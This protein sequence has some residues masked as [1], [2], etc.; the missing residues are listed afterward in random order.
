MVWNTT[1]IKRGIMINVGAT[2]KFQKNIMCCE[3]N[4]IRSPTACSCENGE[5]WA[6]T[7]YNLLLTSNDVI[8]DADSVSTNVSTNVTS[9]ES[10]KFHN[11]KIGYKRNCCILSRVLLV[12][13][14]LFIIIIICYPFAKLMSNKKYWRT[15]NSKWSI[16]NFKKLVLNTVV[17]LF[18][19]QLNSKILI[20]MI[21]Y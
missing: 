9:V 16:I 13:I 18:Q 10:I 12:I 8:N 3:K 11:K 7:T 14:S 20:L 6:R 17:L 5:Y 21:L 1:L 15:N 19:W 2:A 4:N